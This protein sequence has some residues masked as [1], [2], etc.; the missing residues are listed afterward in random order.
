V[1]SVQFIL[2]NHRIRLRP[3]TI[4]PQVKMP[5]V[6]MPDMFYLQHSPPLTQRSCVHKIKHS[7]IQIIAFKSSKTNK[8][9]R[10]FNIRPKLVVLLNLNINYTSLIL[11]FGM[12]GL[13]PPT[14]PRLGLCPRPRVCGVAVPCM[15]PINKYKN[16]KLP[17]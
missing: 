2:I 17:H 13:R 9:T 3:F 14:I 6:K 7:T 11:I 15:L 1:G 4:A 12:G 5:D 16:V 8:M 10:S